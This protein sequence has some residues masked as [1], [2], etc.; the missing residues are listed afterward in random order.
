MSL[1]SA[2]AAT[3][4]AGRPCSSQS[5]A[6]CCQSASR[7]ARHQVVNQ[8]V[9]RRERPSGFL[10]RAGDGV[11]SRLASKQVDVVGVRQLRRYEVAIRCQRRQVI[12]PDDKKRPHVLQPQ[13]LTQLPEELPF[14]LDVD[15]IRGQDLLEL[16]EDQHDAFGCVIT[17]P[18]SKP[19]PTSSFISGRYQPQ[20][21]DRP[22]DPTVDSGERRKSPILADTESRI[23]L[24][25]RFLPQ[26][27]EL[28][29]QVAASARSH[30]VLRR[31]RWCSCRKS[32]NFLRSGCQ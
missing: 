32:A 23:E 28:P 6:R 16:I 13:G 15:R 27:A 7:R 14:R 20:P 5:A 25:G 29:K 3:C 17:S 30:R 9:R 1:K 22:S 2:R 8:G 26:P 18:P 11:S 21:S 10:R 4:S 31:E 12:L 19:V 24:R